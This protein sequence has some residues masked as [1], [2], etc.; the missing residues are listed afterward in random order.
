[1]ISFKSYLAE[2]TTKHTLHV[3]DIDDTLLHTT[4]KIHVRNK[5][6]KAV[7]RAKISLSLHTRIDKE[8]PEYE[9]DTS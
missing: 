3:F 9:V 4:A 5:E 1:M 8:Q 6:G 2:D 7:K